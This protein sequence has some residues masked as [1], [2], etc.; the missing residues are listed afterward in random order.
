MALNISEFN[1]NFIT[2]VMDDPLDELTLCRC[3][4]LGCEGFPEVPDLSFMEELD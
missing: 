4:I 2:A 3:A 1:P